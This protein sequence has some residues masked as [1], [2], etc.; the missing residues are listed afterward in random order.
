MGGRIK[1]DC[2]RN[3][4]KRLLKK[5][6]ATHLKLKIILAGDGLYA[7]YLFTAYLDGKNV[8]KK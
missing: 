5:I 3:A 6:R 7:D 8:A 1:Q 2:E 4:G